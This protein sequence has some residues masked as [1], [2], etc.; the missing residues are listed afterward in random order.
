MNM[1]RR[2]IADGIYVSCLASDKFK[3][4]SITLGIALP[5]DINNV[6]CATLLTRVLKRGCEKYPDI[7]SLEKHLDDLYASGLSLGVNR[8]GESQYLCVYT[9]F[10]SRLYT[11]ECDIINESVKTLSEVLLH[12]LTVNGGFNEAYV[13][14]E[15]KNLSDQIDAIINNKAK[16]ARNRCIE[17]MCKNEPYALS[18]LGDKG[19]LERITPEELLRFHNGMIK[20][21]QIEILYTGDESFFD[22]VCTALGTIFSQV[23]RSCE[24]LDFSCKVD[25]KVAMLREISEKMEINQG[26]LSIGLRTG[27][28]NSDSDIGALIVANEIFG[29]SPNSKLFM[30]V[31]EK[32]SLCYYCSSS[33][34]AV[35]GLMFINAG[36][37]SNNYT[38]ARDAIL[39]QL[40]AVKSGSFTDEELQSA[41]CSL[42][43]SYKS[44]SDSISTLE[45][46]YMPRI[47]RG[48]NDTPETRVSQVSSVTREDVMR[49]A[50]RIKPD[51][52]FFLSGN[53]D[54]GV[55]I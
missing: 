31:R 44:V 36:I 32:M 46:W 14:S 22:E 23:E 45:A 35:K 17:E 43:N 16:Y 42:T 30:N 5:L 11:E 41:K 1:P 53:A 3:V 29:G 33:L 21:G 49:A 12:P 38:I 51:V 24:Q 7:P 20:H 52:I 25:G 6:T 8:S 10:L 55:S 19:V 50:G 28:T 2:K 27:I 9:D 13:K 26:K 39:D 18:M 54:E 4:N 48:E 34:D 37:E 40:E 15:K 47:F